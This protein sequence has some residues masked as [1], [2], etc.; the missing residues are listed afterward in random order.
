M[1]R[2]PANAT[3]RNPLLK[4]AAADWQA[5]GLKTGHTSEAG[6]GLVAPP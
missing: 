1:D 6:Y 4:I 3:N 5:D 2:A